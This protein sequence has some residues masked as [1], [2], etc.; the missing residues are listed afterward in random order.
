M[1][2][3]SGTEESQKSPMHSKL[4]KRMKKGI[5]V[6]LNFVVSVRAAIQTVN[7]PPRSCTEGCDEQDQQFGKVC[8]GRWRDCRSSRNACK[9]HG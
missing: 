4:A 6:M 1:K 7:R 5:K 9:E 8:C 2:A 3:R